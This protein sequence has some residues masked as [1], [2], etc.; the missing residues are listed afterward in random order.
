MST[1]EFDPTMRWDVIAA[2][3]PVST[4]YQVVVTDTGATVLHTDNLDDAIARADLVQGYVQHPDGELV[5]S[6]E[7]AFPDPS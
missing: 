5:Y 7:C 1:P 3:S 6:S 4:D 2:A